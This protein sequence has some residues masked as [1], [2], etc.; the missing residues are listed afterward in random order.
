MPVESALQLVPKA[1]VE[2]PAGENL[3]RLRFDLEKPQYVKVTLRFM[4]SGWT[5]KEEM[6][7][8]QPGSPTAEVELADLPTGPYVLI[9]NFYE[10]EG[11]A[12]AGKALSVAA[13]GIRAPFKEM[14]YLCS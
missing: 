4:P 9:A 13:H 5:W 2:C 14:P 6:G 8:V 7:L 11:P 1:H 10:A 3:L 12:Y